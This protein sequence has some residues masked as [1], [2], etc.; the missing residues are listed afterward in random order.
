MVRAAETADKEHLFNLRMEIV[1]G[2]DPFE[3]NAASLELH[4]L[5]HN[6]QVMEKYLEKNPA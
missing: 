6:R 5:E 1:Q 2:I 3:S 4:H